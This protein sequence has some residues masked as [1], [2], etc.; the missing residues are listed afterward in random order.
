MEIE[1]FVTHLPSMVGFAEGLAQQL[2][3]QSSD[4]T[5]GIGELVRTKPGNGCIR[6]AY[7][8]PTWG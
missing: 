3:E 5:S 2:A 8:C 4:L 6:G 7:N 1:S